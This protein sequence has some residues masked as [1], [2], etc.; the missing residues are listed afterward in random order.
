[1][2][3]SNNGRG[4]H[5][6]EIPGMEKLRA[7]PDNW[8]AFTNLD[9]SL[10]GKGMREIDVILVLE[11]RLL[12]VDL[13]DWKGP[14]S[15]QDG[16]WFNGDRDNGR[17]P[18]AKIAEITRELFPLLKKFLADQSKREGLASSL[19]S[20]L[21]QSAVVLTNTK[22]R[23]RIADSE[24]SFVFHV[25]DFI[26]I[27]RNTQERVKIFGGVW[28]EDFTSDKWMQRFKRF[29]NVSGGIFQ[30]GTRRYGGYVARNE[31][32]TFQH[33]TEV[34][35]EFEVEEAGINNSFG[36]LRRWN[37]AKAD[38]RFQTEGGRA[39]IAGRERK[40]I[41]WLDDRNPKCGETIFKPRAEDPERGVAYWEV[42]ERRRRMK[43]LS[44]FAKTELADLTAGERIELARQVLSSLTPIH[45][46]NAAH[47]DVGTH[48]IWVELPTTVRLSHLMAASL[49]DVQTLGE[50]RFQFLSTSCVPEDILGGPVDVLRK[51]VFLLGCVIHVLLFGTFPEGEPPEWKP[52]IHPH[53]EFANLHPWFEKCLDME[54]G[55]RFGNAGEMLSAFNAALASVVDERSTIEGL[56]RYR[57]LKTQRDIFKAY[58]ETELLKEDERT[59]IWR[60]DAVG[61]HRLVKLWQAAALG[62]V[63]KERSRIL[64][65][66]DHAQQLVE[67]PPQGAAKLLHAHWTGDAIVIV[68]EYIAG[69]T[70]AEHTEGNAFNDSSTTLDF[71]VALI[72]VLDNL[73]G[74]YVAHGDI[75][76]DNIVV[77][78]SNAGTPLPVLID[79]VDFSCGQ[80]GSRKS[81]AYSPASGG[82]F[83]R[84]RFAVTK[85]AEELLARVD[86]SDD[87]A[88]RIARSIEE[89]RMGP[90]SN[91]TLLPL[92]EAIERAKNSQ[93]DEAL[94]TYIV[95]I[96]RAETGPMLSDEG[97]YWIAKSDKRIRIL[98]A[99]EELSIELSNDGVPTRAWRN[100]LD[101]AQSQR[102]SR[103]KKCS[104]RGSIVI[105]S[106]FSR[107]DSISTILQLPEVA[108]ALAA[109]SSSQESE[110]ELE[111]S[112]V[113]SIE[114]KEDE[115]VEREQAEQATTPRL[116]D[117]PLLWERSIKIEGELK[118]EVLALGDSTYRA[119][120]RLHVVP[121]QLAMGDM[122]FDR[123]DVVAVEK[124]DSKGGWRKIGTLD[125]QKSSADALGIHGYTDGSR[126]SIVRD[127]DRLRFQSRLEN[128]S[129][130][131]REEAT[132][133]ILKGHAVAQGLLDAFNPV[134]GK[135]PGKVDAEVDKTFVVENYNLNSTQV[136]AFQGI[137]EHRPLG[138][139]Q[140][141]P[142]TGKTHFIGAL[143]HYALTHG[144]ARNVLVASQSHEAV[145]NAAEAVLNLF[146]KDRDTL[147][148]IRVGAEGQVSES[149][150]PYHVATVEKAY[151]DSFVA[152]R[153]MRME[154]VAN[155]LGLGR[156]ECDVV[157]YYEETIR[158]ILARISELAEAENESSRINS[159]KGT[160]EQCLLDRGID[161]DLMDVEASEVEQ[162]VSPLY[163]SKLPSDQ[164]HRIE[165][166]RHVVELGR[167]IVGTVSTW[168]RSYETFLA[169]TRQVVTGTCVGLGRSSLGL[170]KTAFDL[171]IVDEAARCTPSE[172]AVPIQAGKWIVLVG[173][174]AQLEPLHSSDVVDALTE[175]LKLSVSEVV[176][177]DFERVFESA[178]GKQAGYTLK[179]QYRMLPPIGRLVSNAFYDRALQ[180][181]RTS[182]RIPVNVL[183]PELSMPLAWACTDSMGVAAYQKR[184][185]V[186]PGSLQNAA[187]ADVIVSLLKRWSEHEPFLSWLRSLPDGSQAIGVICAYA[188]QLDLVRRKL[189]SESLPEAFR[190]TIKV[191]T[192]DSYQGKENLVVMLSLVRNNA[193]GAK[194]HGTATINPGFMAK[195]N[196][197]NVALSRAMD[198]LLIVGAK[199][200]WRDG[201]PLGRI[202]TGFDEEI[203]AGEAVLLDAAELVSSPK[204]GQKKGKNT[205]DSFK[206]Q[207]GRVA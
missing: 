134:S 187:E 126:G 32:P 105:E 39:E 92:R 141:P 107:L 8:Q 163:F 154:A 94:A 142:G 184:G 58:P 168:Q 125:V 9:L 53:G 47:L 129:W 127:G 133:R 178:Y 101:Q 33:G 123:K 20:P 110:E 85:I 144:L 177:S 160:L 205:P 96:I 202:S 45:G 70:L 12:L 195:K 48:S 192:I 191:D 2:K 113:A 87:A 11:D 72:D 204:A 97:Q 4:I 64:A 139:L 10:P 167:D 117:V 106:G 188:A 173:D 150:R 43:R 108:T 164:A 80:D 175:E 201:S 56:E 44:D 77:D 132:A 82:R 166:L 200:G 99:V 57:T 115:L 75:K 152:T 30:P 119:Q 90:P 51:D 197:V 186:R 93:S 73:H 138:L 83:E 156:C 122:D 38:T 102:L 41:A 159:L 169:G 143:V 203:K 78:W 161:C 15:S 171:V 170:T 151:K 40:V 29:F 146:G 103:Q 114:A 174:H 206:A 194:D 31:S 74:R 180:H 66:L 137:L 179:K 59:I 128:S 183:P 60:S 67:A 148:M 62:N 5:V 17:S 95:S 16:N 24:A 199:A 91:G 100:S 155:Y 124:L 121:I 54:Q 21:I 207:N 131:R 79:L 37:F 88:R 1:M 71:I 28:H 26:R 193:D 81:R 3:I 14:I 36:L 158:P 185:E 6:R 86:I 153:D 111:M 22:D 189:Q 61:Q 19:G 98:G 190:R 162:M 42:F 181:G 7:L 65:F 104:F 49:P 182:S 109:P 120:A 145:N 130:Q 89:C 76:P 69:K 13:K 198:R 157:L 55:S 46:L 147:S 196:R 165:R 25:D 63:V 136:D 27:V 50:S 135:S 116:V 35:A 68:Q 118:T 176:R 18:V 112:Q 172:L 84:D 23:S 140:G 52:G 149:L 34:Y